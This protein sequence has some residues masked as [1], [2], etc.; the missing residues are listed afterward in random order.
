MRHYPPAAAV[1]PQSTPPCSGQTHLPAVPTHLPAVK[2]AHH[3]AQQLPLLWLH[4]QP[5]HLGEQGRQLVAPGPLGALQL[6]NAALQRLGVALP[7]ARA[8]EGGGPAELGQ[9]LTCERA[10]AT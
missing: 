7:G 10:F 5:L 8:G 3:A 6:G 1:G 2:L 4:R 9:R